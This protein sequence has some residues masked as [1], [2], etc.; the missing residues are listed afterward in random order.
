MPR[1]HGIA[2]Y[3]CIKGFALANNTNLSM[4]NFF[5]EHPQRGK[6]FAQAMSF[7]DKVK[8]YEPHFLLDNYPWERN[9]TVVDVGGSHGTVAISIAK[10][11]PNINCIV[12]D[13][14]NVIEEGKA[15]L[16][17]DLV[18][19]VTF[20][21]HDFFTEQ[22]VVADVYYFRSIFHNWA[23][24]YCIRILRS[25]IPALRPGAR[26]VINDFMVPEPNTLSP[27]EERRVR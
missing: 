20:M 6:K 1:L 22:P 25:L 16:P 3:R 5:K 11:F 18:D 9:R 27:T 2:Y 21:A 7:V 14:P 13:L 8:G 24:K 23:D 4:Y 12:Q 19:R 10:R 26:V 15:K 17:A